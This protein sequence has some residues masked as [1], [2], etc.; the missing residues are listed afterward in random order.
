[1][2]T[3]IITGASRGIGLAAALK[4]IKEGYNTVVNYNSSEKEAK[5]LASAFPNAIA[6]KADITKETEAALLISEALKVFGSADIL[7]NNAGICHYGLFQDFT[8]EDYEK[9]FGT[10]VLGT[11][12]VTKKVL[13]HMI[14]NQR[15]S[16]VNISSVWGVSGAS[17]EVLYSASKSAVIGFTKALAKEVA[18]SGIRVNAIAPGVTDTDMLKKFSAEERAELC[19]EIPLGKIAAPSEIAEAIFFLATEKS[20]YITG[21]V[22]TIDGGFIV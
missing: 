1:M 16:I 11:M 4:F 7:I 22:L 2:K 18:P 10:N 17:C 5:E 12:N 9:I 3:V 15:G 6:V 19:N 8:H 13:P 14:R 21:Q 20:S